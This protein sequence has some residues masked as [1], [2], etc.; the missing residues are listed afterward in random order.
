MPNE[1]ACEQAC[2]PELPLEA[3][4]VL[5]SKVANGFIIRVGCKTLVALDWSVVA[6]GLELY[7][8]DPRAAEELYCKFGVD[9]H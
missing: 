5:I 7:W 6:G 1:E 8:K 9:R 2:Q 4:S 3:Q